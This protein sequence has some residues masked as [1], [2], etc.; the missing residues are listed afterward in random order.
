MN[1]TIA[2]DDSLCL[3]VDRE[4][5]IG[6]RVEVKLG[7]FGSNNFTDRGL[8]VLDPSVEFVGGKVTCEETAVFEFGPSEERVDAN[9][10]AKTLSYF[11]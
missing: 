4:V 10:N 1:N 7:D 9:R 6:K 5:E 11:R 2:D 3:V 8:R